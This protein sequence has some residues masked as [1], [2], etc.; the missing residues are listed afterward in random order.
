MVLSRFWYL[1]LAGAAVFAFATALLAASLVNEQWERS[2]RS[3]LIR[4]RFEVEA[5]LKLDARSRLDAIA[6]IAANSDVRTALQRASGRRAGQDIDEELSEG[7]Q[8]KLSELNGQ[9]AGMRGELL[10]A[11]DRDGWVVAAVAPGNVPD[12]AGL[13]QFP[14][15]RRALDGYVRDD[16]WIYNDQVYRMA[17]RPVVQGGQYV[18]ALI[19]GKRFDD[20]LAELLSTRLDGASIGFFQGERGMFAGY[21]PAGVQGAPR[22]DDMGDQQLAAALTNEALQNGE[23]TDPAALPTGGLAVYSLV[24][25]AAR[26]ANVGYAIARPQRTLAQPLD[27]L[28]H[29]SGDAWAG[30]PWIPIA[31]GGLFAF[32]I[33]MF[34]LW[35]ERD[36]PLSKLN[37]HAAALGASPE[38]RFTITDFGGRYR[39]IANHVN[40]ALDKVNEAGGGAGPR[41]KAANLD[42]IL[43]PA[44]GEEGAPG[45]GSFFGF[46]Q[47]EGAAPD[48]PEVPAGSPAPP[49]GTRG[50][51]P[52]PAGAPPKP[53]GAPPKPPAA[54]PGRP[55]PKPPAPPQPPAA[56]TPPAAA[57]PQ[58]DETRGESSPA[59]SRQMLKS[60]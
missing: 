4:D 19:H 58:D 40:E 13:G 38:N 35:L 44:Q 16:V 2:V 57:E 23:R 24:T 49:A 14:L 30:L 21:M 12:G 36:R 25:G 5:L 47:N 27:I 6:P 7:L 42:E 60:T 54:G 46:A 37:K 41:R 3:D 32:L 1:V 28:D 31:G 52:P 33:A 15:V 56:P 51:P 9:L 55:P 48:F 39:K 22:R 8:R 20:E 11:V 29:V 10:F 50:A 34:L 59:S 18:G 17:A 26:H 45:S 53:P 43:G